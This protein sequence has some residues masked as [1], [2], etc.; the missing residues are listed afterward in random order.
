[1][2]YCRLRFRGIERK[3]AV[4]SGLAYFKFRSFRSFCN[5]LPPL[6]LLK[7]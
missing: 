3:V 5:S 1:M 4:S 2:K 6:E 7:N